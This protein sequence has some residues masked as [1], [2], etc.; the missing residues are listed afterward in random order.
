VS[1]ERID[2]EVLEAVH[3]VL[4]YEG[5]KLHDAV[6]GEII[7]AVSEKLEAQADTEG[8]EYVYRVRTERNIWPMLSKEEA[9]LEA[10]IWNRRSSADAWVERALLGDWERV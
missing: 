9:E 8:Q 1:T 2:P 6:V 10:R 3:R 7:R 5:V 4:R